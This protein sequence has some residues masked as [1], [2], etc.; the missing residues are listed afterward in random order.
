MEQSSGDA[1]SSRRDARGGQ[2]HGRSTNLLQ[3]EPKHDHTNNLV[4]KMARATEMAAIIKA[5]ENPSITTTY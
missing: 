3:N 5:S 2:F 4:C 1:R